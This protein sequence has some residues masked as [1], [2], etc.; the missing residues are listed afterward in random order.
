MQDFFT[1]QDLLGMVR[2]H[3]A[4]TIA[5][6]AT[7]VAIGVISV[8]WDRVC[9][10]TMRVWHGLPVIGTVARLSGTPGYMKDGWPSVESD[11]CGDY[12]TYYDKYDQDSSMYRKSKDYLAKVGEAGRRPMPSWVLALAVVLLVVE[13]VGFGFVLGPF[14]NSSASANQMA[15]LAWSV[16]FLL[17]L[18]SGGFAHFAGHDLHYNTLVKK[19]HAWW[20]RDGKNAERPSSLKQLKSIHLD[21]SFSDD[22]Q[23]DY[24]QIMARIHASHDVTQKKKVIYGFFA[25]ILVLAVAA[26]WIRAYTLDSIET[27]M[28]AQMT[29]TSAA[30]PSASPFDLP[31]ES[32]QVNQAAEDQTVQDKMDAVRHASLVTYIVLS[33]VYVA[34]QCLMLWLSM[35]FGFSGVHSKAAWRNTHRFSSAEQFEHWHA[36]MRTRIA[37]HADHKLRLL[38]QKRSAKHTTVAEEQDSLATEQVG[39]RNFLSYV[40]MKRN[41]NDQHDARVAQAN[42]AKAEQKRVP[43]APPVATVAAPDAATFHDVTAMNDSQLQTLAK[44]LKMEASDLADVRSQ[45]QALKEIGLFGAAPAKPVA[46]PEP[47]AVVEAPT[48]AEPAA[49]IDAAQF[50]DLTAFDDAQLAIA[51]KAMKMSYE[52]LLDVR[53][54]QAVLKQLGMFGN[55]ELV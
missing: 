23:P 45:Q 55:K 18:I 34:I 6:I 32:A 21:D 10:F 22:D 11:V 1:L 20:S 4:L 30:A 37:G 17:A 50:K 36:N 19:A 39:S 33:V 42:Q 27:D 15:I 9:Y 49:E 26:F 8:L 46:E 25:V 14:V 24:Q 3:T 40:F 53:A 29:D 38:Q 52:T 28:V 16:A 2:A 41:D 54:Q 13:A 31:E 47:E 44:A 48:A 51:A 43:A 35:V 12:K 7:L 5:I